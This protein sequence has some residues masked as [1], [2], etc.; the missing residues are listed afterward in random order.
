M[1]IYPGYSGIRLKY[2]QI[3]DCRR[4]IK[5]CR[6]EIRHYQLSIEFLQHRIEDNRQKKGEK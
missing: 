2:Q 4:W 5:D 3:E 1:V 6:E